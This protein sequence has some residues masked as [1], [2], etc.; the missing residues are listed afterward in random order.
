MTVAGAL[1]RKCWVWTYERFFY[2]NL[3]V[4]LVSPPGVGKSFLI[5]EVRR[6]WLALKTHHIAPDSVSRA[7]L[8]DEVKDAERHI[9]KDGSPTQTF[10]SLLIASDEFGTLVPAYENDMMSTLNKLYDCSNYGERKRG[11]DIKYTLENPQINF[12]SGTTP[13]YL[14]RFLPE[15][16]WEQGFMSRVITVYSGEIIIGDLFAEMEDN[17]KLREDLVHDLKLISTLTGKFIWTED[18]A[19]IMQRWNKE[20]PG[21]PDHPKLLH[22]NTRRVS[23]MLKLCQISSV[24]DSNDMTITMEHFQR[25]SDWL[26]EAEYYMPDM[27]KAMTQGGDGQVIKECFYFVYKTYIKAKEP[28]REYRVVRFLQDRTP[29]HNLERLLNIMVKGNLLKQV[30]VNKIGTCYIPGEWKS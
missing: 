30:L 29:S 18:A 22:Y 27:F 1:E 26:V 7:S 16:A 2:P 4:L 3:F 10:N 5:E 23:Q 28:V 6:L 13:S 20:R 9:I 15:G 8:L 11:S 21:A 25:A 19:T 17:S 24:L 14:I 12:L